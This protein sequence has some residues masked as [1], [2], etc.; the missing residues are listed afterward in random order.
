MT[1]LEEYE[2]WLREKLHKAEWDEKKQ[3]EK[4]LNRVVAFRARKESRNV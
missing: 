4:E 1:D 2:I 3:L